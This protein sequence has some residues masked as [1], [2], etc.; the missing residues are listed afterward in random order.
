MEYARGPVKLQL[1]DVPDGKVFFFED[2]SGDGS[3]VAHVVL[4]LHEDLRLVNARDGR[5]GRAFASMLSW[6]TWRT[7]PDDA[8]LVFLAV[9]AVDRRVMPAQLE[10]PP[11]GRPEKTE[12]FYHVELKGQYAHSRVSHVTVYA[13]KID[14]IW[15]TDCAYCSKS[16]NF[17]RAIGRQIAR[18]RFHR[19]TTHG[20]GRGQGMW[21][22]TQPSYERAADWAHHM[23]HMC[24]K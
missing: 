21:G 4:K 23:A 1:G 24:V 19:N 6:R 16:D 22:R 12:H 15:Y 2:G 9:P 3:D 17:S 8:R 14:G 18:N 11:I 5:N 7:E 13:R 10:Y 20:R